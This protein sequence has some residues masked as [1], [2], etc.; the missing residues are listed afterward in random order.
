MNIRDIIHDPDIRFILSGGKGGVGKT[1]CAGAI[2]VLSA[3]QGLRTLVISTD[4]AHSLSDSFDQD[5][6]GGEVI[7]IEGVDNLWGME[8][9]AQKGMKEFQDTLSG[10]ISSPEAQMAAQFLVVLKE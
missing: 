1:T 3:Q 2:A 8:I 5:L 7:Q 9:N 6:S 10:G 4:P